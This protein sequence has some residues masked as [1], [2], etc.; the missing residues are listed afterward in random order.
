MQ[1]VEAI[2]VQYTMHVSLLLDRSAENANEMAP[3][4]ITGSRL[5]TKN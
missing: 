5:V 3:A 2:D 4:R 1:K